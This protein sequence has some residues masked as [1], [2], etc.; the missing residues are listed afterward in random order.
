[1]N[2]II[3]QKEPFTVV[4][5]KSRHSFPN[6]KSTRDIPAFW[7]TINMDFGKPLSQLHHTFT[8]SKHCECSIC[9]DF[10]MDTGE[11]TYLLGV[12]IDNQEDMGKIEADMT[13]IDLP[14]GLYAI[15]TTPLT[16]SENYTKSINDTWSYILTEWLPNSEYV[17]DES[18]YDFEYYDERDH[19]WLHNNKVQMDI[20]IPITSKLNN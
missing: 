13:K 15:F 9:Y 1:M 16:D 8:K 3:A 12:G 18:R 19:A 6:V 14:G 5:F 11:F 17:M 10:D 4:G 20:N 7:D 2:P